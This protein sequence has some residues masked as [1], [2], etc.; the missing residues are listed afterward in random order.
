MFMKLF[1]Y[2]RLSTVFLRSVTAMVFLV[3]M[4]LAQTPEASSSSSVVAQDQSAAL[5][6][7]PPQ[8]VATVA[9]HPVETEV[10][11]GAFAQVTS[12][13]ITNT[14][15]VFTN[16]NMYTNFIT[17]SLTPSAGVLGTFRQSFRPWLGYVV[18]FGYTR[19]SVHD[20]NAYGGSTSDYYIANDVYETSIAYLMERHF[21]RKLSGFFDIGGGAMTFLPVHRGATAIDYAPGRERAYVPGVNFRPAG[22]GGFGVD[23][24]FNSAWGLRAEYR[25]QIYKYPDYGTDQFKYVTLS[26]EPTVSLTY[27]FGAGKEKKR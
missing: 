12:T 8:T 16:N 17:Q 6:S 5:P 13:R 19:A 18:N 1:R 27:R 10:S 24:Q 11:L 15:D 2:P 3:K 21:T 23:Y 22:V 20:T 4:L 7:S 26:N 25:G 14:Y 9:K